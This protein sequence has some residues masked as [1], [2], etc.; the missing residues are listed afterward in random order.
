MPTKD[1]FS[2]FWWQA[3]SKEVNN[4]IFDAVEYIGERQNYRTTADLRHMRLYG[5]APVEGLSSNAYSRPPAGLTSLTN[6]LSLNIV[7]SM[8]STV[9]SKIMKNRPRPMFLTSGGDWSMKRKAKMLNK[10]TQG[11]FYASKVYKVGEDVCRDACIF[12]TGFMKIYENNGEII[13]ERVFPHEIMVDDSEA[14]YGQPRQM[15]QR[16]MINKEVLL[17]IYPEH[18]K[19][20]IEAASTGPQ[21][22]SPYPDV[23]VFDGVEVIEAWHLPSAREAKD[24]RHTIC[25]GGAVLLDEEYNKPYFPFVNLKWSSKALGFWGQ[26]IAEQ[27]TGL[28]IEINKLLKT[29]QIAMHLVS[30]PK[31]F[32]ERG[33]K[34]SKA[35]LNNEIGG[36]IEYAGTPP[37][38]KTA[39][40]V[41]PEMFSH[42]DRLYARAYEIVGVS[43]LSAASR[44]PAGLESGRALREF[45]DIE[46]ERFLSFARS[47]ETM[48]LDAAKIMIDIAR[49]V[50]KTGKDF[51]VTSFDRSNLQKVKW[52]DVKLDEDQ[53][54]MQVFPTSLLPV[55]PAARLQTVEEMMRTGLLS[56]E[57]GMALLDFPDL[58][59]VQSL[60]TASFDE[61]E[62]VIESMIEKGEY[63]SPEPFSN[64]AF[65]LKK[66]NQAYIRAKLDGVPEERLDLM[67][68]YVAECQSLISNAEMAAQQQQM[69]MMQAQAN[70]QAA[71]QQQAAPQLQSVAS[72]QAIP[73]LIAT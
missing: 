44:K 7:H 69:A 24:G 46:S 67:R 6:R 3:N 12:G 55:T 30:V 60:E 66:V 42:L 50:S 10:F 34:V 73:A 49:D 20:I 51:S 40:S 33:S 57:D 19:A 9:V 70:V 1:K 43:Q 15:F 18:R 14:I 35:H 39:N 32:V 17:S 2:T 59:S 38:Y 63:I 53:Y 31:V 13:A 29:I 56:R 16:K 26:G 22:P 25:I 47:Y 8:V 68:R 21:S 72:E 5:N 52:S 61:I 11:L 58:K 41:S 45:S 65:A 64:L 27:L 54:I 48:F 23:A 28:Q 37:V 36:I 62:M 71:A 4:Y